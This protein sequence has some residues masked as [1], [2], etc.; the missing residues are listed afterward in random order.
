MRQR[1][2]LRESET[3][4]IFGG[5]HNSHGVLFFVDNR[6]LVD[7]S[8]VLDQVGKRTNGSRKLEVPVDGEM[9]M[10]DKDTRMDA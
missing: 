6:R 3:A 4:G 8:H 7:E 9:K 10:E 5:A 1:W 2:R